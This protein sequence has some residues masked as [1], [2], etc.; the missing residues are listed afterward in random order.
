[1][2]LKP[3]GPIQ[4]VGQD[5][6]GFQGLHPLCP[7]I[8]VA[9]DVDKEVPECDPLQVYRSPALGVKLHFDNKQW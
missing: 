3:Q 4:F 2:V 1:M 7:E 5:F 6:G 8:A 9:V